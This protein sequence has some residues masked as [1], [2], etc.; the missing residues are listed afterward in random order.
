MKESSCYKGVKHWKLQSNYS[1][2][3]RY[4][5]EWQMTL[6]NIEERKKHSDRVYA[7][8]CNYNML[9]DELQIPPVNCEMNLLKPN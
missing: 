2:Q 3:K 7:Q 5:K 9:P 4:K 6:Q 8:S 1:F